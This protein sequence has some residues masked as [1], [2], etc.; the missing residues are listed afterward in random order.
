MPRDT[1][2][3]SEK[4]GKAVEFP[5]TASFLALVEEF[6]ARSGVPASRMGRD[7]CNDAMLVPDLRAGRTP[8]LTTVTA[9]QR[10]IAAW[11]HE[12]VQVRRRARRTQGGSARATAR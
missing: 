6:L 9:V 5:S 4:S 3:M 2:A 11:D 12:Q 1:S 7:V 10:Y 8:R